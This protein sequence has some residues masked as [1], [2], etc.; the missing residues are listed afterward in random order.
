MLYQGKI[1]NEYEGEIHYDNLKRFFNLYHIEATL[2]RASL[3]KKAPFVPKLT[4][5]DYNLL[6]SIFNIIL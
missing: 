4:E 1:I 5:Y 3:I 2:R 6:C